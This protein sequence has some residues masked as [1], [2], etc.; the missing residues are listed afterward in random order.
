LQNFENA[1]ILP[2]IAN[3]LKSTFRTD[4]ESIVV[5]ADQKH[6]FPAYPSE[7]ELGLYDVR[8]LMAPDGSIRIALAGDWGAGTD[9]ANQV[10]QS[11]M[12][13]N[14]ELTIHLGDI[15]YV[16]TDEEVLENCLGQ[17]TLQYQG[18][19][20]PVGSK[21][22]FALNGN[23]EMYS[24]GHGYFEKFSPKLGILTSQDR[25][26]LTSYFCLD[27]PGWRV[28]AIDTGYNAD[29]LS[30]DCTLEAGLLDWL[31]NVV[32]PAVNRKPTV[33][34]SHHQWF[35]GVDDGDYPKPAQQIKSYFQDQE[36]VWLWSHEHRLA[37]Y[38]QHTDPGTQ[39]SAYC[40]CIGHGMPV[41][42]PPAKSPDNRVEYWDGLTDIHPERFQTLP[43]G[44]QIAMNGYAQMTIQGNT[45]TLEYRDADGTLALKES[46]TLGGDAV[47]DGILTRTVLAD[48]QLLNRLI[49]E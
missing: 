22:S 10:A 7:G 3:W 43:D 17:D 45:L 34:L 25:S 26:Q 8:P 14:P 6:P 19:T 42:M 41:E 4:I 32:N 24:G 29:T 37:I 28:I 40:R 12:S 18:V 23:H 11:M 30:G 46:F 20:W 13:T 15:Y 9:I 1:D 33:L 27:S 35:S 2:W 38:Y 21:G 5:P 47:W 44:T 31:R 49:W 39:L 36:F 16:G 48:P